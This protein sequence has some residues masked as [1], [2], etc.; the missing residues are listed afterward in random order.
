MAD[1]TRSCTVPGCTRP[2]DKGGYCNAHYQRWRTYGDVRADVP[3]RKSRRGK[4]WTPRETVRDENGA[5][6]LLRCTSTCGR[7]LPPSEFHAHRKGPDGLN[8]WCKDCSRAQ[9]R[10]WAAEHREY[11][12]Q[13]RRQYAL[14]K[15]G[16]TPDSFAELLAFQGGGCAICYVEH[17]P[18]TVGVWTVDHDHQTGEV[19]GILCSTCNGGLGLFHDDAATLRRAV[20][21]LDTPPTKLLRAPA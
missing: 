17:P 21:Y 14:K 16:L 18:W 3:I 5:P 8:Y 6:L 10:S 12:A 7:M 2:L 15:Y 13:W 1:T 19:R 4:D 20:A 9:V 11:A